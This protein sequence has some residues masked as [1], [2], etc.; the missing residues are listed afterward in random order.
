VRLILIRH[1]QSANNV[2]AESDGHDYDL[3]MST[4][5]PEPP[6]TGLG[7][8]QAA[9]LAQQ[10]SSAA[11]RAAADTERSAWLANEHPI[12]ELYVSP[13]LRALQT[14]A[15]IACAL[16]LAPQVWVDIHEH[17]GVFTGNPEKA[18]VVSYPGLTRAEMAAQFP[19]YQV[20]DGV[21]DHGWWPGGYEEIEVC[22]VR[23]QRVAVALKAMAAARPDASIALVTHGTFL[24]NLMH[25]LF[26]PSEAY[27]DRVHFSSLNT[28]VSRVDFDASGRLA[29]RY[30]NRID[31]LSPEAVSR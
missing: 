5:S 11:T 3:Y 22:Y 29:L 16:G 1:G 19:T 7:H 14:A 25:A 10:L 17:G 24:D 20:C 12:S 2:L 23:A 28:A 26:V 18:N 6:L 13:M 21:G 27:D 4:R 15:P 31:H 8:R 9:L 30:L